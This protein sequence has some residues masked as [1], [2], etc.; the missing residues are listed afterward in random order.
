MK[1]VEISGIEKEKV[2]DFN[3]RA[4]HP[5]QSWEW[6]EFRKLQGHKVVRTG[7]EKDGQLKEIYQITFHSIPLLPQ[8]VGY[9]PK[10]SL[11]DNEIVEKLRQI[12]K[13]N[14]AI[15]IKIEP[16]IEMQSG[17]ETELQKLGLIKGKPLF[18]KFTSVIDLTR[19]E[20]EIFSSFKQ[21]TRYNI[22]LA[23]KHGIKIQEDNSNEAFENYLNLLF[24]TTSRQGFYAHNK[25]YHRKQWQILKPAGISHLLTATYQGITLASFL[26]FSFN[27]VLYYPY[28]ASTR[29]HKELMAPTLLMWEAIKFGKKLGCKSFDLWGDLEPNPAP[30]HPYF[31]FHRFKD[32]FSPKLLEFM[33]SYDLVI[34]PTLYQIYKIIDNIRWRILRLRAKLT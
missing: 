22:R 4:S 20:E 11:L 30:N 17:K 21:K 15:F 32:G 26:L 27:G 5:L 14:K 19:P 24:E 34:N 33:G 18:T 16:N 1:T 8:T 9:L 28:G 29:E 7:K 3:Q 6:G 12:G 2:K 31:G 13:E 25:E 10:S 23:E